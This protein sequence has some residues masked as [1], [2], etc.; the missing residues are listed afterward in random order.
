MSSAT[1]MIGYVDLRGRPLE[2]SM[3][4]KDMDWISLKEESYIHL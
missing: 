2:S 4:E 3:N 1:S